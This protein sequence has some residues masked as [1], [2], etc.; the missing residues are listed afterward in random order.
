MNKKITSAKISF[1]KNIGEISDKRIELFTNKFKNEFPIINNIPGGI[2]FS[3]Q[4]NNSVKSLLIASNQITYSQDGQNIDFQF[5]EV[6]GLIKEVYDT[7]YIGYKNCIGIYDFVCLTDEEKHYNS[8]KNKIQLDIKNV[9]A[10]GIKVFLDDKDYSGWFA[11]E[12]YMKNLKRY[13]CNFELQS[14]NQ[15]DV[16]EIVDNGSNEVINF[17]DE[18]IKETYNKLVI[19]EERQ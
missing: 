6:K 12:P 2:I 7:I 3:K 5:T 15:S 14:K 1:L 10:V 17:F 18:L 9:K 8:L 4:D 19:N 13:F 11:F 16:G